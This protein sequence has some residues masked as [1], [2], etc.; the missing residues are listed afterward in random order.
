MGEMEEWAYVLDF[1]PQGMAA[2][3]EAEPLAQV[4]GTK[5][6][7]LLEVILKPGVAVSIESKVYVGRDKRVE[8]DRIKRRIGVRELTNTAKTELHPVLK[9]IVQEREKD[10]VQFF[11]KCGPISIRLHQLELL[12]G[13]G[14]KHMEQ[15][16]EERELRGFE[17]FAD[18]RNRV[19]LLSDPLNIIVTRIAR[20]LEGVEKYYLFVKPPLSSKKGLY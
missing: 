16:L 14:K 13:V 11:N 3:R 9:K 7:T 18:I 10:F 4:I 2:S 20:E 12:P 6:F 17:T 19:T 5:F 15:I 8:V 1:M